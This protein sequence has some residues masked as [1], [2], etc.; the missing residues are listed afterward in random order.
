MTNGERNGPAPAREG[1]PGAIAEARELARRRLRG[2]DARLVDDCLLVVSELVTN[3]IRHGGGLVG[4]DVTAL[5]GRVTVSVQDRSSALP[6][7][8]P[9]S[10]NWLPGGYGWPLVCRLAQKVTISPLSSGGK[11]IRV[12]LAP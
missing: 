7:A 5:S 12:S 3:A 8:A 6:T 4:V 11:T 1:R 10:G 9:P 2:C